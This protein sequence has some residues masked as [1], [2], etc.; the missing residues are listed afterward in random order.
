MS[1]DG[2]G[3]FKAELRHF[4]VNSRYRLQSEVLAMKYVLKELNIQ[5]MF[6]RAQQLHAAFKASQER[7]A[8]CKPFLS[9]C[10]DHLPGLCIP[11]HTARA[12]LARKTDSRFAAPG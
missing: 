12:E 6:C 5:L 2:E 7:L 4:Y 10:F 11:T 8:R 9:A 3:P 1:G